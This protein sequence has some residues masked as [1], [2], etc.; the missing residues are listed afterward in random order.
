MKI[1]ITGSNGLLG[2][3]LIQQLAGMNHRVIATGMGAQRISPDA[4]INYVDLDI[5]RAMQTRKFIRQHA[6]DI[7]IHSAAM[8]QVDDCERD[9][10][11]SLLVNVLA[12]ETMLDACS[13]GN[14][15]FIFLSTD[16]VF[17]GIKGNYSEE[18]P[19]NP[20]NWYGQTKA[21]AEKKV[22]EY[23]GAWAIARTCLLYGVP[24][25]ASR[26]NIISWIKSALEKG[27]HIRVLNDQVRTPTNV[28][29]F[30]TGIRLIFE[31][32]ARGRF[33]LSGKEIMTPYELAITVADY[34]AFDKN[35]IEAVDANSFSQ[36]GKR[37]LK[38]GFNI[39][40]AQQELGFSPCSLQSG[41]EESFK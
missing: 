41:L 16:F 33:H 24:I 38:T 39:S 37:P 13:G 36:L 25:H 3:N 12:T 20:V 35:L 7:L 1:L 9:Q 18:D 31:K 6:P 40:K 10:E 34:F 23:S 29:D 8:T 28:R 2:Q 15:H 32:G 4:G 11:K 21:L 27:E 22:S 17:D 14:T 5:T 30:A 26:P 19:V